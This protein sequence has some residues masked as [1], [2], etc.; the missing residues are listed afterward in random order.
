MDCSPDFGSREGGFAFAGNIAQDD[1]Y[2]SGDNYTA[3]IDKLVCVMNKETLESTASVLVKGKKRTAV[4]LTTLRE[5][6]YTLPLLFSSVTTEANT[7]L[8]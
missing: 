3:T 4:L 6:K 5:G 8:V 7:L 1:F 2:K